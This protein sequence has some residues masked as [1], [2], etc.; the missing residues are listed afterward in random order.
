MSGKVSVG[1]FV[2]QFLVLC[3]STIEFHEE[4][5]VGIEKLHVVQNL[6]LDNGGMAR[7]DVND[8]RRMVDTVANPATSH[9]Q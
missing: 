2:S 9:P 7:G 5:T 1:M 3:F 8:R 6:R 4:R